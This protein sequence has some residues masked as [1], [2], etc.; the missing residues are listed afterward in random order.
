MTDDE[1]DLVETERLVSALER[2]VQGKGYVVV[3]I[4]YRKGRD[5]SSDTFDGFYSYCYEPEDAVDRCLELAHHLVGSIQ[6]H[7]LGWS[8][9]NWD[10]IEDR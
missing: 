3:G 4:A 7:K 8:T 6:R 1:L 9:G 2:R 5:Y 10:G